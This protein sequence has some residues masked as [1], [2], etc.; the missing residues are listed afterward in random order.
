[1]SARGEKKHESEPLS[2]NL[3]S[4][5][6]PQQHKTNFYYLL[7]IG[8]GFGLIKAKQLLAGDIISAPLN[9]IHL[10]VLTLL[11]VTALTALW[12]NSFSPLLAKG[13]LF[14]LFIDYAILNHLSLLMG[15]DT[16]DV[17]FMEIIC[18]D[19]WLLLALCVFIAM[20][21]INRRWRV[22]LSISIFAYSALSVVIWG[23]VHNAIPEMDWLWQLYSVAALLML[24]IYILSR[25]RDSL[26]QTGVE[27]KQMRKLANTDTLTN[28]ANRRRIEEVL[29]LECERAKRYQN[30]LAVVMWDIDAFKQVNDEHGHSVGDEVLKLTTKHVASQLREVDLLGR[31]GGE[32]F[33]CILP[34]TKLE[35]AVLLAERLRSSLANLNQSHLPQITASFGVSAISTSQELQHDARELRQI[36]VDKA[37][38]ELYKAKQQG[39]NQVS[40]KPEL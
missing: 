5:S 37:D 28:I 7:V 38:Q 23:M 4:T 9:T 2:I 34:E 15:T 26:I 19:I 24:C 11:S 31:W 12:R 17:L 36:L 27:L 6:S 14:G 20:T 39:R 1:M 29:Q 8:L 10:L 21:F 32:E 18:E 3:S 33:L 16:T 13:L 30:T 35:E 22:I 25:H 40:P